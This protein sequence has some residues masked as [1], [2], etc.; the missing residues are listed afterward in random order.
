M[1][2]REQ[3]KKVIN[4][5]ALELQDLGLTSE[6]L[7]DLL[8]KRSHHP[9][10]TVEELES[11]TGTAGVGVVMDLL[12]DQEGS[13]EEEEGTSRL[14]DKAKGKRRAEKRRARASYE[15]AGTVMVTGE[16]GRD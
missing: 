11:T 14:S 3:L 5:V 8:E 2:L 6:V 9:G 10:G 13:S 4:R 16:M 7:R 12:K 15:L 1:R